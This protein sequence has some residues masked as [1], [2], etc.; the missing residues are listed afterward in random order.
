LVNYCQKKKINRKITLFDKTSEYEY[1]KEYRIILYSNLV[2]PVII[3][4]GDLS[5]TAEMFEIGAID[6]LKID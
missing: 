6:K 3:Q 2:K 4:I 1:Q 5:K